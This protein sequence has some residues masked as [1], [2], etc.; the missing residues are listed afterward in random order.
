MQVRM[1]QQEVQHLAQQLENDAAGQMVEVEAVVHAER[2]LSDQHIR[3]AFAM[4]PC[5]HIT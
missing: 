3:S 1:L 2:Q 5:Q 4:F